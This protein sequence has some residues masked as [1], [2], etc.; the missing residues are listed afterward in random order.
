MTILKEKT[1]KNKSFVVKKVHRDTHLLINKARAR[2]L[3]SGE[4]KSIA[5]FIHDSAKCYI[6]TK[7]I[8]VSR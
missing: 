1:L 8:N 5:D 2:M 7:G 3:L 6:K 4:S